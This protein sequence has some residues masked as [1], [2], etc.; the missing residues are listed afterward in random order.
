MPHGQSRTGGCR[1]P[2]GGRPSPAHRGATLTSR[3]PG[4]TLPAIGAVAP[5]GS[6]CS[7][8]I[9]ASRGSG[10]SSWAST[11]GGALSRCLLLGESCLP[12]SLRSWQER[13]GRGVRRCDRW[14]LVES[15]YLP[16]CCLL[17]TSDAADDLLCVD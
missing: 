4:R 9:A 8:P 17:Y 14:R 10:E 5:A 7:R 13:D 11:L 1:E 15:K 6:S 16:R 3:I 2:D 12:D